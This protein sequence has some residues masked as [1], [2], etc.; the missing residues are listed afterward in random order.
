MKI[1]IIGCGVMG[2][3]IARILSKSHEIALYSRDQEKV[4]ALAKE[5]G[6]KGAGALDELMK[7][8]DVVILA[9]KPYQLDDVAEDLDPLL[10]KNTL[11]LSILSGT[12]LK[13]LHEK[14]EGKKV[15]AAAP[16]L[17]LLCGKGM[18]GVADDPAISLADKEKVT[19]TL[20]SLGKIVWLEEGK[21]NAFAALTG[22]SPAFIHVI[23]EA[24]VE[25]G[26]N[27]GFKPAD[28]QEYVLQVLEGTSALIRS[29]SSQLGGVRWSVASPQG[30]TI[31]GLRTL[32]KY[33]T[34]FGMIEAILE[35]FR[36]GQ[37]LEASP[38]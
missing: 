38:D 4:K 16:N 36:K 33:C 21:I 13:K 1:G 3:A 17:A 29:T 34:R 15:F 22:S 25:A 11:L 27:M 6:G 26:I 32:E 30:T 14:F 8:L 5:I 19:H 20:E 9:I 12:P 28:A 23:V 18:I 31:Q 10:E 37:E 35:T 7:G 2:S 24:M